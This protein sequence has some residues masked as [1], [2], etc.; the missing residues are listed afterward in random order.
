MPS[1]LQ[2]TNEVAIILVQNALKLLHHLWNI[3]YNEYRHLNASLRRKCIYLTLC[4]MFFNHAQPIMTY[5]SYVLKTRICIEN[6]LVSVF[7]V[8]RI[9][10]NESSPAYKFQIQDMRHILVV[11]IFSFVQKW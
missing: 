3:Q 7:L 10:V 9:R 2:F 11:W 5:M 8:K 4:V 6:F 1:S